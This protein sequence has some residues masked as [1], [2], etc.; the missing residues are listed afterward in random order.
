MRIARIITAA[1]A[2]AFA[3]AVTAPAAPAAAQS[4]QVTKPK[5]KTVKRPVR[6]APRQIACTEFGCHP[7]PPNCRPQTGYRWDGMPS[8]FDII[9]CR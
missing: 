5:K 9:V 8:G 7:I 1:L 3:A 6:S 2:L 4:L